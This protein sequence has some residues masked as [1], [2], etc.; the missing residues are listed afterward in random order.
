MGDYIKVYVDGVIIFTRSE[1]IAECLNEIN[2]VIMEG[3]TVNADVSCV[4]KGLSYLKKYRLK[5]PQI[6]RIVKTVE[7]ILV[8]ELAEG[9]LSFW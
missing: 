4:L 7:E 8:K 2:L 1:E 6:V 3:S 9:K 5:E